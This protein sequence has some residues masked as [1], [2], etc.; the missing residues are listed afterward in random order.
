M[1][2]K[3]KILIIVVVAAAV[4]AAVLIISTR[5]KRVPFSRLHAVLEYE[6]KDIGAMAFVF[7]DVIHG[8]PEFAKNLEVKLVVGNIKL[9][10]KRFDISDVAIEESRI[11]IDK[12]YS[13]LPD[14]KGHKYP[15]DGIISMNETGLAFFTK[16]GKMVLVELI[17]GSEGPPSNGKVWI[18]KVSSKN[19]ELRNIFVDLFDK[20]KVYMI[21]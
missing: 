8:E 7:Y 11:F 21:N 20:Y 16:D 12:I 4:A 5:D 10:K 14:I 13:A 15:E 9:V 18:A 3:R 19:R 1:K 6:A 17:L 2:K